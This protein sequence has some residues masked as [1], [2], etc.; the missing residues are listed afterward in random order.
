MPTQKADDEEAAGFAAW[1]PCD[2]PICVPN[3][4]A[5]RT[6]LRIHHQCSGV[7]CQAR[8]SGLQF[9]ADVTVP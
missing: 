8:L 6:I 5:A 7:R 9:I 1:L 4:E 2:K 3:L